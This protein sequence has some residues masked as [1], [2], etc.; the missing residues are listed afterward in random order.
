MDYLL[1]L[2][3]IFH[4]EVSKTQLFKQKHAVHIVSKNISINMKKK[5]F[6]HLIVPP[7]QNVYKKL[8]QRYKR[9][10]EDINNTHI[11]DEIVSLKKF[12][13]DS[14]VRLN[15]WTWTLL[16]SL[17]NDTAD[18]FIEFIYEETCML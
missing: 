9:V 2:L 11:T 1:A 3:L 12:N 15:P 16:T 10:A 7:T 5:Q 18:S 14:P 8:M 13:P 6:L 4:D 17:A